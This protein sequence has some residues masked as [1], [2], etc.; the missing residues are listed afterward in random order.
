[1][2]AK[3]V[4]PIDA[5]RNASN[6]VDF[7]RGL[8][9]FC[10]NRYTLWRTS[11]PPTPVNHVL[12]KP[13]TTAHREDGS[14]ATEAFWYQ[15]D[16]PR[17][18]IEAIK[19]DR[20]QA[21][22]TDVKKIKELQARNALATQAADLVIQY[23]RAF[24]AAD[25]RDCFLRGWSL[26]ENL[27]GASGNYDQLV[28]RAAKMWKESKEFLEIAR[29][30]RERRN[31]FVHENSENDSAEE[32][33]AYK[34]KVLIEPLLRLYLVNSFKFSSTDEVFRFLDLP[35]SIEELKKRKDLIEKGIEFYS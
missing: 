17:R 16:W 27:T 23:A 22:L 35:S 24:D 2:L 9:N 32:D 34:I 12:E 30:L 21:V 8:I 7:E 19:Q 18:K 25:Y 15:I 31:R 3:G 14:L 5:Y 33:L 4:D 28:S 6:L 11:W 13:F 26:L 10:A 29:Y 1:M 20:I